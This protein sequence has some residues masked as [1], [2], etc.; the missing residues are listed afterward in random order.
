MFPYLHPQIKR[1]LN[2]EIKMNEEEK[3]NRE[4]NGFR[5]ME[6][7]TQTDPIFVAEHLKSKVKNN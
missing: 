5:T 1:I 2:E 4:F 3:L 7:S 6:K